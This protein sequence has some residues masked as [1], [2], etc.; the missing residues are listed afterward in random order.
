MVRQRWGGGGLHECLNDRL[1]DKLDWITEGVQENDWTGV[2][3]S[4]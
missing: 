3:M 1:T 2:M 4:V